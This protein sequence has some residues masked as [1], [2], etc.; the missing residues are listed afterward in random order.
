[1]PVIRVSEATY[2][3]LKRYAVPFADTPEKVIARA[4]SV[5]DQ[6]TG[7]PS[8][9]PL[10][11]R[12]KHADAPRL[13]QREFRAPLLVTLLDLGGI[14][15]ARA[16]REHMN[17]LMARR[18]SEGDHA[19]SSSGDPR[20]WS[21]VCWVRID[22][23]KEG[24]IKGNSPRGVWEIS[25]RGKFLPTSYCRGANA[26][27]RTIAEG[28]LENMAR[29]YRETPRLIQREYCLKVEGRAFGW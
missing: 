20:W 24:L 19:R 22:L 23:I 18:L 15:P 26:K 6:A 5:L 29:K 27:S 3:R 2:E 28:S 14:A 21:A 13:P 12:D 11:A 8:P 1:M 4:L 16:V 25:E 17:L 10:M 7:E 9:A